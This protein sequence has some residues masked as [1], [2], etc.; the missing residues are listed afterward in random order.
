MANTNI[1][2]FLQEYKQLEIYVQAAGYNSVL[3]LE[4]TLSDR[5]TQEKLKLC[6]I[7]RN[8]ISHHADGE[9]FA[10]VSDEMITFI[11]TLSTS[12]I[13]DKLKAG[14][15]ATGLTP[16][17]M[18]D[19]L[20]AATK[21][22]LKSNMGWIPVVAPQMVYVGVMN[23]RMIMECIKQGISVNTPL[24]DIKKFEASASAEAQ[25]ENIPVL[26]VNDPITNMKSA[27]AIVLNE[28]REKYR[29]VII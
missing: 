28:K 23:T 10:A 11:R 13:A 8:Y 27:P 25:A 16:V 2:N 4:Q 20:S 3:D 14:D 9:I 24:S 18:D 17:K 12:L 21:K 6:R 15:R 7:I 22:L 19:T 26:S 29:G 1:T 5:E